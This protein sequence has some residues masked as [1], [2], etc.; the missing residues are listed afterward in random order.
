LIVTRPP[1]SATANFGQPHFCGRVRGAARLADPSTTSS[2][3]RRIVTSPESVSISCPLAPVLNRCVCRS[4]CVARN[5][6][7]DP[8]RPI[9]TRMNPGLQG[10]DDIPHDILDIAA[11]LRAI[12]E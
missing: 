5:R 4:V 9:P 12:A 6:G 8:S 10:P 7:D 3:D 11:E 1:R 2:S